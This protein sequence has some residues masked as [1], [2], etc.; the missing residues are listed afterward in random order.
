MR[1]L[2]G[3]LILFLLVHGFNSIVLKIIR[4]SQASNT[5]VRLRRNR[6]ASLLSS[7]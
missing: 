6:T 2:L 4:S 5:G 7:S 1:T 3:F